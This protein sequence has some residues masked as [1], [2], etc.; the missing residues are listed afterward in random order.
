MNGKL[1]YEFYIYP[2]GNVHDIQ[3]SWE[4]ASITSVNDGMKIHFGIHNRSPVASMLDSNPIVFQ[5]ESRNRQVEASFR[6]LGND[7]YGFTVPNY[8]SQELLIIGI[9]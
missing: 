3:L 9:G 1:K 6:T 7:R 4:G 5:S 2:G 8:N